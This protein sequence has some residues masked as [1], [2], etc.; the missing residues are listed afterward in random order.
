M[1]NSTQ[2]QNTKAKKGRRGFGIG[3]MV[4]SALLPV[5]MAAEP[6]ANLAKLVANRET[7]NEAVRGNYTY[8]Q[9]VTMEET[10]DKGL[11]TGYYRETSE[12][13]FTP[14]GKR[15]ERLTG[16]PSNT[17]RRIKLTDE[18]F[19]DIR[20]VQPMLITRDIL[21]LYDTKFRGEE[22]MDG[23]RCYLLEIKPRQILQNQ[24]LFEGM[25]WIDP[26]DYSIVRTEGQAV[27]QIR[28]LKSENLFPHFTTI[29]AKVDGKYW[30]PVKTFADDT[31]HFRG[32]PQR[33]RMTLRYSN[34]QKF[35]SSSEIKFD[36]PK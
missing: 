31:L 36:E 28:T 18:D 29:R 25:L 12:V 33:V 1:L 35:S 4:A 8:Q 3:F 27:P 2:T 14:E 24:R 13:I 32:G 7:E 11:T 21:F 22:E 19:R 23:I 20:E 9:S 34:Y 10:D 16:K 6:P 26:S 17:M 15:I 5:L 30:F